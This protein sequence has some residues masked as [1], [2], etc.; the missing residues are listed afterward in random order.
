MRHRNEFGASECGPD[1]CGPNRPEREVPDGQAEDS[2]MTRQ[3]AFADFQASVLYCP[4]C[5]EPRP[6][7][8][9][10]LLV[11]PGAEK[12]DYRCVECGTPVG[13]RTDASDD[14]PLLVRPR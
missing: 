14:Q 6:V 3:G 1:E 11:L 2:G 10:L 4:T 5:K 9:Q 7:R 12:Y 8:K 13:G